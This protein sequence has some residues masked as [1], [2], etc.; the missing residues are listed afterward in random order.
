MKYYISLLLGAVALI[1]S[2][3]LFADGDMSADSQME[4]RTHGHA[5]GSSDTPME[6][7]GGKGHHE[8]GA[9]GDHDMGAHWNA[10]PEAAARPNPVAADAESIRRGSGLYTSN[11]ASCHGKTGRGDG[12][13]AAALTPK[14][15]DLVVMAPMHPAG[16]LFWKIEN[17]RGMMPAWKA[18]LSE[19]QMWDLVNYLKSLKGVGETDV[20]PSHGHGHQH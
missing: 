9:G 5:H 20:T 12:P 2:I 1:G 18:S 4:N 3:I 8:S 16:D 15:V 11:C 7:S 6:M 17:G 19:T 14:P 13:V 10:P